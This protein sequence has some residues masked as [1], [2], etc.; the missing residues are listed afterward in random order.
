MEKQ[1][2]MLFSMNLQYFSE[3]TVQEL[4]QMRAEKIKRQEAII[5]LAKSEESRDLTEE[6]DQE[7]EALETEILEMDSKIEARQKM[8]R[9]E[10]IVATRTKELET[11]VTP[12]RP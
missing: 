12:Y 7:F 10:G 5:A 9:R 2:V 8:A 6:E 11:P 1:N 4:L 3:A